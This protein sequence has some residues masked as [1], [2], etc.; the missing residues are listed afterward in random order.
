MGRQAGGAVM[1]RMADT[2]VYTTACCAP[3]PSGDGSMVPF[4][5]NYQERFSAAGRTSGGYVKRDSRPRDADVLI[6]RLVDRPLRP[7]L[8][9]GWANETQARARAA[10]LLLLPLAARTPRAAR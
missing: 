2:V 8:E 4:T 10:P 1:A 5:V 3:V 6:S 7:M 9:E